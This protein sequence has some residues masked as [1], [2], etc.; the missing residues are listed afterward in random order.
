MAVE[1]RLILGMIFLSSA[2]QRNERV[3]DL[4]RVWNKSDYLLGSIIEADWDVI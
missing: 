4:W 2:K 1:N 3:N